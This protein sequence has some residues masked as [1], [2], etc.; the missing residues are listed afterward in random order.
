MFLTGLIMGL[1]GAVSADTVIETQS[2]AGV[3]LDDLDISVLDTDHSVEGTDRAVFDLED[4]TYEVLI[5]HPDHDSIQRT[6]IVEGSSEYRFTMSEPERQE[7]EVSFGNV[8]SPE[9]VC[10]RTS[11]DVDTE[12]VN[13]GETDEIVSLTGKGFGKILKGQTFI[14]PAGESRIHRFTF[15]DFSG[16]GLK[17]FTIELDN[18]NESISESIRLEDCD[19]P[20]DEISVDN[21]DMKLHPNR[22]N[23][24]ASVNE[25][26]RIRGFA[27]GA[28]GS[29]PVDIEVDGRTV[30]EINTDRGGFFETY[31]RPQSSGLKTVTASS[32][33]EFKSRDLNVVPVA[34][35]EW[36]NA[37]EQAFAGEDFQVCGYVDSD[38]E[39]EI[40]L[41][42][43]N[44]V[45][46]TR[47]ANGEVCF[48][49]RSNEP[50]TRDYKMRALTYGQSDSREASVNILEQGSEVEAFPSQIQTVVSEPGLLRV[51]LYNTHEED[52]DYT[53]RLREF[54]EDWVDNSTQHETL[55][56]GEQKSVFFYANPMASGDFSAV[57]EVETDGEIIFSD[58]VE[59]RIVE[60]GPH[61]PENLFRVFTRLFLS[62][63]IPFY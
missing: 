30:A 10:T 34:K 52:R 58:T 26:V 51:G 55:S 40:V 47:H 8:N 5:E 56:M 32:G 17:D 60:Q 9:S 3:A 46:E 45:I 1:A 21:V 29:V 50:G 38:I 62:G 31:F 48:D 22:G 49:V 44:E 59:F 18:R 14:I 28:R 33:E 27:D 63:L 19:I 24:K 43:D 6:I 2:P 12:I 25:L 35:I 57:L 41:L 4:G 11:F 39:P 23:E 16:L 7:S 54:P 15:T 53:V 37:P 42:Q 20:G 13:S 61:E 36:M